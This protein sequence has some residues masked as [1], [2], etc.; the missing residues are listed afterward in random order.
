[1]P[2][3]SDS[4]SAKRR[5]LCDNGFEFT[6]T[7]YKHWIYLT[8]DRYQWWVRMNILMNLRIS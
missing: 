3:E 5:I 7:G 2:S 4:S 8:Q 1:V 6:G